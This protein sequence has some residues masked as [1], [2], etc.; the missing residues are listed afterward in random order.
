RVQQDFDEGN[1]VVGGIFTNVKR[2]NQQGNGLEYLHD[3]AQSGGVDITQNLWDRKYSVNAKIGMSRVEGTEGALYRTQTAF[4][5]SFQRTDN[6]YRDVDSTLTVLTGSFAALTFGK[7]SGKL[8]WT[9][10]SN[11]RSPGLELNDIGFLQQTDNI[12]NWVW[13]RYQIN[14]KTKLFRWQNY[15]I[16]H[17]Q[18]YDFGGTRTSINANMNFNFQFHNFWGFETGFFTS[19]ESISNADLRGGPSI[20][21]PGGTEVWFWV[22]TNQ[23][24]KIRVSYSNW[25]FQGKDDFNDSMGFNFNL[26]VRPT[27]AFTFSLSPSVSFRDNTLQYVGNDSEEDGI[28]LLSRIAQNTYSMSIRANYNVTPNLTIEFW[29]QPFIASGEFSEFKRVTESNAT[30]LENRFLHIEDTQI[31]YDPAADVFNVDENNLTYSFGNPNFNSVEFRSNMVLR[32]EY[33][34]GS[35]LFLVWANN[36]SYNDSSDRNEFRNLRGELNGLK[37]TNTFLIKLAHRFIR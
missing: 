10:G 25:F 16:Y 17:E 22:G 36:G 37:G 5:R 24:K 12:N 11:Y 4:R 26:T 15:S 20:T 32:W 7:Q 21:Y 30:D 13:A 27:D 29:G 14:D 2:F 1:T 23:Q 8:N 28:Y 18:N 35:T 6:D 3:N 19:G 31:T 34:P 33:I 9:V